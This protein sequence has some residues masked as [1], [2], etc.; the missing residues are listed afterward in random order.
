MRL[1]DIP[2]VMEVERQ[3][4]TMPWPA[5][6][7]RREIKENRLA[8]YLVARR[9]GPPLPGDRLA[10]TAQRPADSSRAGGLKGFLDRLVDSLG[11][12]VEAPTELDA[13]AARVVGYAGLWLMVDEAHVTAIAVAPAY[14]GL[15]IGELLLLGLIDISREVEAQ[16]LTLEV[17]VSNGLAQNLYRKYGFK[18]TGIRRKYYS[19]DN[20]DALIMWSDPVESPGLRQMVEDHRQALLER[21][22]SPQ[23]RAELQARG[24][25]A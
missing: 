23:L 25:Q 2:A 16:Y 22:R 20:E 17:R 8:R 12:P 11:G 6:A 10:V 13:R 1:E 15:G 3:S 21:F 24:V 9:M 5:H 4:F 14:R 18:Q 19:D 7:Y